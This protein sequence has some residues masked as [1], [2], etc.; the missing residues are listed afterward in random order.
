MQQWMLNISSGKGKSKCNAQICLT[1]KL[2]LYIAAKA[3]GKIDFDED[4]KDV[5][6]CKHL[7]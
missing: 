5:W 6:I 7:A 4:M 1:G 3:V 2:A